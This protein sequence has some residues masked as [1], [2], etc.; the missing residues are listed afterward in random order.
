MFTTTR[1]RAL[2]L[3]ATLATAALL[4]FPA[5]A[6]NQTW[7]IQTLWQ[8]G[9]A[10]QAAFERFA[11]N[12]KDKTGGRIS[13]TPLPSGAVVGVNETLDAVSM[14]LLDGQHPATVY[15]TGRNP[16]FAAIGDLNAA[17]DS[18][19]QAMA[20][21]YDHGGH[22][23]LVEAYKPL[24][25][26][27]IGA[28]FWGP[29]SVPTSKAVR[30]P[31]DLQGLKIRLPQGMASE[32]FQK[33]GAVPVNL[34]GSEVFSAM[35]NGTIQATDWGTLSMNDELGFHDKAKF[36]IFPGIHSA[37]VGDVSIRLSVWEALD[38]ETQATLKQAMKDFAADMI[39]AL[40]EEDRKTAEKLR[41][42]GVELIDWS[43]EDRKAFRA[44]AV[45]VWDAYAAKN[46]LTRRA[47]ES[48]KAY[49]KTLGALQ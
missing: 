23:L 25:L 38:A 24:G 41:A 34:P 4:S 18:P 5:A 39:A 8:P 32:L 35:D 48:Q 6:Q 14:G 13:I 26:Y 36:A 44:A 17:Y 42:E 37:P 21:Y 19:E 1:R 2:G 43:A 16:A 7:R 29:E 46:D 47:V 20:W 11:A 27:P 22:E 10:N 30:G 12:V 45:E 40:K 33:F 9:T 28:A 49:L 31:A 3:A 15:W